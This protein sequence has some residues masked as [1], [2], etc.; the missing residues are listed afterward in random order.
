M[1]TLYELILYHASGLSSES[2]ISYHTSSYHGGMRFSTSALQSSFYECTDIWDPRN[3]VLVDCNVGSHSDAFKN[4][5]T[6]TA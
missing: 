2:S 6:I 3:C 1:Y 5:H 4:Q